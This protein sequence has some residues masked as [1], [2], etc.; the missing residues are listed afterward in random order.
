M[1]LTTTERW[2]LS[3]QLR[4]LE[5]LYPDEARFLHQDREAIERGY[6]LHYDMAAQHIYIDKQTMTS[7]ECEEVINILNM[8]RMIKRAYDALD[9]KSGIEEWATRFDGF[10]G[11]DEPKQMA[12]ARYYCSLDGGKFAEL[13]RG[14]D[15]NSHSPTLDA[16]RRML[17]EWQNSE[18]RYHLTKD[19][20]VRIT[21]AR[22]YPGR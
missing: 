10:D 17:G 11:N 15:F 18:D 2:I 19:D 20:L 21:S 14:D 9:D 4:I 8:F 12:Y 7:A 3:N 5:A 13:D 6:E 1:N 16:Y 22:R